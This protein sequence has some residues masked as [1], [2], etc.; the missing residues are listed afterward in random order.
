[1][2]CWCSSREVREEDGHTE[3]IVNFNGCL[4]GR[5]GPT[6]VDKGGGDFL[7]IG[8]RLGVRRVKNERI[9]V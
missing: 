7:L 9:T 5:G 2:G 4:G 6:V 3:L 8:A 1:V